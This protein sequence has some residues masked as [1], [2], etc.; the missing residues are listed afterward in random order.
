MLDGVDDR[1]PK[2]V[3]SILLCEPM[4]FL[5]SAVPGEGPAPRTFE[6]LLFARYLLAV[7]QLH[8]DS[9][10]CRLRIAGGQRRVGPNADAIEQ[11]SDIGSVDALGLELLRSN[12]SV[13]ERG[14]QQ[15]FQVVVGLLL[16]SRGV[17][18]SETAATGDFVGGL[19]HLN[20]DGRDIAIPDA[21]I[22]CKR[23]NSFDRRLSMDQRTV[24]L[25]VGIPDD[26]QGGVVEPQI[27]GLAEESL[28]TVGAL[29]DS[30]RKSVV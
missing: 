4:E 7:V 8:G 9:H 11:L 3:V 20:L 22:A 19:K 14:C 25:Q 29:E 16:G 28:K 5:D 12:L 2:T 27:D 21:V 24:F 17:L 6:V 18:A 10:W 1:S 30:D 26:T 13:D 15:V 23:E